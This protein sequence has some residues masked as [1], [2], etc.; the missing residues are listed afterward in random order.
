MKKG[1]VGAL[2]V[3]LLVV[4]VLMVVVFNLGPVVKTAVNSY[5][6][7]IVKTDV[8][9]DKADVSVFKTQV[10]FE[11]F[12]LGNPKGFSSPNAIVVGAV[13]VD[14][15]ETT[16]LKETVIINRIEVFQPEITYEI[17]GTTDNFSAIIDNLKKPEI[18]EKKGEGEK[19][20]KKGGKK[21]VIR[22]LVLKDIKVKTAAEFAGGDIITTTISE[23][24]LKNVGQKQDGVDMAQAF[25]LVINELYAQII[26]LDVIGVLQDGIEGLDDEFDDI[27]DGMDSLGNQIKGWF[28]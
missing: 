15:D 7:D 9:L 21:I 27:Q 20:E 3:I 6:P 16:L 13:L 8:R 14:V 23:I 18:S 5:G 19:V 11:N 4:I 26:S 2:C 25:L 22:D 28:D 1:L 12:V 10:R 24:H 17:N